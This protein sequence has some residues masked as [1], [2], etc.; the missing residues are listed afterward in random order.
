MEQLAE[1]T[2]NKKL[3]LTGGTLPEG[4][5]A[6]WPAKLLG[7]N[8]RPDRRGMLLIAAAACYD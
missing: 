8:L 4:C 2:T 3:S 6:R 7:F 1:E 5:A